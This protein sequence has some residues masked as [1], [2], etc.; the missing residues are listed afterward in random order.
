MGTLRLKLFALSQ[1]LKWC[2]S[3]GIDLSKR[4]DILL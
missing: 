3:G 4:S 2:V 1:L